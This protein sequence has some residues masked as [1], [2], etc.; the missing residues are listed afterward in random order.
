MVMDRNLGI[1]TVDGQPGS[2]AI[3]KIRSPQ[4]SRSLSVPDSVEIPATYLGR[5]PQKPGYDSLRLSSRR[6]ACR[7]GAP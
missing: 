1:L 5:S 4:A 2:G 6:K 3:S 7:P